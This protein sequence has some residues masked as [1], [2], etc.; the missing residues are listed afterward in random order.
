MGMKKLENQIRNEIFRQMSLTSTLVLDA[1]VRPMDTKGLSS[2]AFSVPSFSAIEIV[3]ATSQSHGIFGML[4]P[5]QSIPNASPPA[6]T[7]IAQV[8]CYGQIRSTISSTQ[9]Y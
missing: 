1:L 4:C 7:Q 2:K 6:A 5:I 8:V 3:A 9:K